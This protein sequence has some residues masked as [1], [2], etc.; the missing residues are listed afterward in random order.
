MKFE[1]KQIWPQ[2]EAVVEKPTLLQLVA[3]GKGNIV[4]EAA[5]D[6]HGSA[7]RQSVMTFKNGKFLRHGMHGKQ[8]HIHTDW[9]FEIA[10][11][12]QS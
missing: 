6:A 3:R 9:D 5:M 8:L 2:Q 10:E 11:E 1:V 4:L 12:G 7:F